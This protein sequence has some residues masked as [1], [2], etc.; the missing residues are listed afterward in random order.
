MSFSANTWNLAPSLSLF[1]I[2]DRPPPTLAT[3]P[4]LPRG[5]TAFITSAAGAI[6]FVTVPTW[7]NLSASEG[8]VSLNDAGFFLGVLSLLEVP[9]LVC[10]G[11]S[12]G[13]SLMGLPGLRLRDELSLSADGSASFRPGGGR[14]DESEALTMLLLLASSAR[15]LD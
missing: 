2:S 9:V 10:V 1:W 8:M 15:G 14:A 7:L 13:R 12:L 5:D 3:S 6:C 11:D 4:G